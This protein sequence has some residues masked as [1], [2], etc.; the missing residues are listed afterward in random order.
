MLC[1]SLSYGGVPQVY[2]MV[3]SRRSVSAAPQPGPARAAAVASILTLNLAQRACHGTRT[4]VRWICILTS[5][6][7]DTIHVAD[8][9]TLGC[10]RAPSSLRAMIYSKRGAVLL[11]DPLQ[12]EKVS[13]GGMVGD[14]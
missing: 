2:H 9:P 11:G 13:V 12:R 3:R 14:E 8:L 1:E 5:G 6:L 7:K 4:Y 10:P